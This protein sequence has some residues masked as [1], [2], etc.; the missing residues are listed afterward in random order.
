VRL[1]P[2]AAFAKAAARQFTSTRTNR[3]DIIPSCKYVMYTGQCS[4]SKAKLQELA[5][6]DR[7]RHSLMELIPR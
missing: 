1:L 7:V 2:T 5:K 6:N 3:H 4:L